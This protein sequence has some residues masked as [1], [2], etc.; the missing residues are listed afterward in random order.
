MAKISKTL[1]VSGHQ[2]RSG[3]LTIPL[4]ISLAVCVIGQ[5]ANADTSIYVFDPNQSTI[6]RSGGIAGLQKTLSVAGRFQLTVDLDAGFAS[7]D[8]V[9]A[10][11]TDET[12]SVYGQNLDEIFNMTG[13]TGTV[14]DDT[15]IQFE[16]K[17]AD[18]TESDVSLKLT[19][20]NDSAHLTGKTTPPPNSA[21]MFFYDLDAV[22]VAIKKYAGGTGEPNDPYQIATAEDLMLLGD[23]PED[24]D[25]HFILTSDIDLDPNLPGGKVFDKA[26]IAP[27]GSRSFIGVFDGNSH[28]ISHLTI[29]GVDYLGLF[30]WLWSGAE[31]RDIGVV[32]ANISGSGSFAG[33]LVGCNE[34]GRLTQCYSTG[35]VS[36]SR[37]AG[38]LVGMNERKGT[39]SECYANVSI[40]GTEEEVGGLV[41]R[42]G[43]GRIVASYSKGTVSGRSMVGGL[44][45][46]NWSTIIDC[47]SSS[48]VSGISG[49]ANFVGG[50]VGSN[51]Y[52]GLTQQCHSTG[53]VS[54]NIYVGGLV[55]FNDHAGM[56]V[57]CYASA[58]VV[59]TGEEVGGLVG[60]NG[61]SSVV[62]CHSEGSVSGQSKVGGLVGSNWDTVVDCSS[63]S[64][65]SGSGSVSN[66]S[67]GLVGENKGSVANS[68]SVGRVADGNRTGGLIGSNIGLAKVSQSFWDL[69][70]SGQATSSQ[71]TGKTT[72]ELRTASTFLDA[73][74]DFQGET[75]NGTEDTWKI[76]E[77]LS[78]PHL[79]WERYTGGSGTADDPYLIATAAE[80][81]ALGNE[82][83]DYDKHFLL[84]ADIDLDPS[85]PGRKVFDKAVIAPAVMD[86][87]I[88][89]PHGDK[90]TG[91]FDGNGHKVSHLTINGESCLGLFGLLGWDARVKDLGAVAVSIMGSDD[92]IGAL[93]ADNE[94][95][96]TR[97]YS[98]G[99]ISGNTRVGGLIGHNHNHGFLTDCYTAD[100]I[101]EGKSSVGGLV[102]SNESGIRTCHATGSVTGD[103]DIGGLVGHN[104]GGLSA[105][106][107]TGEVHCRSSCAGGLVGTNVD[108]GI[109]DACYAMGSVTGVREAGGLVGFLG[110]GTGRIDDCYAT[111]SV[112][113]TDWV[114]G[115]VGYI[116]SS[117]TATLRCCYAVGSVTG[118]GRPLGG[119]VADGGK[120]VNDNCFWD[121]Q[122]SGQGMSDGGTGKTTAEMQTA[123]TFLEAGWD[124][125]GETANGTEDIWWVL[126]GKDYPRLWWQLPADDFEDGEPE[127]LWFVYEVDP[128]LVRIREVNGRLET[129]ASAQA[130]N[131]DA[132]YVSDGWRLDVTKE[133]AIR[134]DF[135]FSH[136]G[137]GDGRVTI[138]V[139]PSLDSSAMQWA[140][141][142]AGCFDTG[143]FYLY[144]VRD[145]TW[146]QERVADRFSDGGT[147]YMSFNPDTDELYFSHSGYGKANAWQTV[148]GL[149]KGRW[150]SEPVY[151][152]LGGGSDQVILDA[153]DAYL[154]NFVVDSGLLDFSATRDDTGTEEP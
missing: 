57:K 113:G 17:T 43:N 99:F 74:W 27:D 52:G 92:C 51:H 152:I 154:D 12:G 79:S 109:L 58:S 38:G 101:V 86:P 19:L 91:S 78:Y 123:S 4:L 32:D 18:G 16:G 143:P 115:L 72:A 82:S 41:G 42:N 21:D 81:I 14:V 145:R 60:R 95:M 142:E 130:Q 139:I 138:G 147:L 124:F 29:K 44:V 104:R 46:S 98:S 33:G 90:F 121:I 11:L 9:D 68:Y 134:V 1:N 30:G 110:W 112:T 88:S 13:L 119:L 150:A 108:G 128:D 122:T 146:V 80:L 39:I 63:S 77:G 136:Q 67:G 149:L 114:A 106:Y 102:G 148:T 37:Y 89:V 97:C 35:V 105:C 96:V 34:Y 45:G 126:E 100:L 2:N 25:K 59:G 111:G 127:P 70:T 129:L 54:G 3:K 10:D 87:F 71:G 137:G 20:S 28:V 50:L 55:G 26:V 141:L 118:S 107:A 117:S 76:A 73:G 8:K 23:S 31:I 120:N 49:S 53:T 116:S 56:I 94:G 132:F 40:V 125:V 62:A 64:Q 140:E 84:I 144:E 83:S 69:Q 65:V 24:Y 5:A 22:A 15:T 93:A 133:F 103:A 131:V 66:I 61:Y 151:V 85:L 153:G 135:H 7:F 75:A 48:Q 36:G 6:V 47:A